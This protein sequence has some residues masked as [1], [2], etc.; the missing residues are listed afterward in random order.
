MAKY[1]VTFSCGHTETVTLFGEEKSR[2]RKIKYLEEH[3]FCSDCEEEERERKKIE[4]NEKS[5]AY[6]KEYAFAFPELQGTP[7]Q[8]AWAE[9]LRYKVFRGVDE[10]L[11]D[12][13]EVY[14]NEIKAEVIKPAKVE[15]TLTTVINA[16]ISIM[17]FFR[18][19]DNASY[20]IDKR[21]D[22]DIYSK[23]LGKALKGKLL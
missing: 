10:I 22:Y 1:E 12:N 21:N 23:I 20:W 2:Q 19:H 3:G 11:R 7:K 4:D 14:K 5:A 9:T 15:K 13:M 6:A 18:T 17:A 8:V 16:S